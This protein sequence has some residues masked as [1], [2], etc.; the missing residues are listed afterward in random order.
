[1]ASAYFF[2]ITSG[3]ATNGLQYRII[4]TAT[5]RVPI[6]LSTDFQEKKHPEPIVST[7][8]RRCVKYGVEY[9][10]EGEDPQQVCEGNIP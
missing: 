9:F 5:A 1:M 10:L 3:K 6:A 8:Q 4:F 2:L 7:L